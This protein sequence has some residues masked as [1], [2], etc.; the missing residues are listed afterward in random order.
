Y[1][2]KGGAIIEATIIQMFG[3]SDPPRCTIAPLSFAC[4]MHYFLIPFVVSHLIVQ[5]SCCSIQMASQMWQSSN[6]T[7]DVLHPFEDNGDEEL[8]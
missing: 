1:G 7:G 3:V 4:F 5:D 8:E 6:Q 2:W